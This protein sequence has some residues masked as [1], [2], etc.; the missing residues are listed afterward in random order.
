VGAYE[1][2]ILEWLAGMD[3]PTVAAV[4]ALLARARAAGPL[5]PCDRMCDSSNHYPNDGYSVAEQT[6]LDQRRPPDPRAEQ[7]PPKGSAELVGEDR[8]TG[9]SATVARARG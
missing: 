3:T 6:G 8:F 5:T 9:Q 1:H 4:A 7:R 2:R